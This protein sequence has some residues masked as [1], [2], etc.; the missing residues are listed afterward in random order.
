[1]PIFQAY[2]PSVRRKRYRASLFQYELTLGVQLI[3]CERCKENRWN[4]K[5]EEGDEEGKENIHT[6]D[7][8]HLSDMRS[9]T[10]GPSDQILSDSHFT[11]KWHEKA[12][13]QEGEKNRYPRVLPNQS[14]PYF[15][16]DEINHD[17]CLFSVRLERTKSFIFE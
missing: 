17:S 10:V 12:T 6:S 15:F 2:H 16:S 4:R 1:M 8:R 7:I 5:E 9:A 13:Q 11:N 3:S 14:N